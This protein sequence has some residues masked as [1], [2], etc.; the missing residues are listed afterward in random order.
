MKP[1]EVKITCKEVMRA[2]YNAHNTDNY[3]F[4]PVWRPDGRLCS[5]GMTLFETRAI[6][7]VAV[8]EARKHE[9]D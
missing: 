1:T 5:R 4:E 2:A 8:R 3:V 6:W 7:R 9:T